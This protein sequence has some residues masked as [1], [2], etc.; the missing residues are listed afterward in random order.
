MFDGLTFFFILDILFCGG[1]LYFVRQ[2]FKRRLCDNIEIPNFLVGGEHP[3]DN[4][5]RG[6]EVDESGVCNIYT[7]CK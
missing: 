4:S 5:V 6:V 7:R 2:R 1:I 3:A